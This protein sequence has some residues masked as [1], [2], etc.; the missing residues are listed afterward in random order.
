MQAR[1]WLSKLEIACDVQ[2]PSREAKLCSQVSKYSNI[3]SLYFFFYFHKIHGTFVCFLLNLGNY[4]GEN[5]QLGIYKIHTYM[6][7]TQTI[8]PYMDVRL[9]FKHIKN[10]SKSS[11]FH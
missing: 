10:V 5:I 1:M 7:S 4:L 6:E 9:P 2:E 11:P 8:K 3:S